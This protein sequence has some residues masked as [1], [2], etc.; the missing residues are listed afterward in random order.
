MAMM[1]FMT[2][3]GTF[4]PA[5]QAHTGKGWQ[6]YDDP[7]P[8]KHDPLPP[9][10]TLVPSPAPTAQERQQKKETAPAPE[11]YT[12]QLKAWQAGFEEAR[13]AAVLAPTPEHLYELQRLIEEAWQK[14]NRLGESWERLMIDH[15]EMDYNATHPTLEYAKRGMQQREQASVDATLKQL[16]DSHAGLFLVYRSSD[17]YLHEFATQLRGFASAS[18]LGLIGISLDGSTLPELEVVKPGQGRFQPPVTPALILVEPTTGTQ[19]PISYGV[20]SV[21]T[22]ARTIHFIKQGYHHA[23]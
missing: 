20:K 15:P 7:E 10:V 11:S 9:K 4:S 3:L 17:I 13:A 12:E 2:A 22:I 19:T 18:H 23:P 21:Q 6:W 8:T 16:A 5:S 14:T 1:M